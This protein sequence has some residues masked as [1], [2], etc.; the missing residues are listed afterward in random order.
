MEVKD[1]AVDD[2]IGGDPVTGAP[3][4][5]T[6]LD[7]IW[8]LQVTHRSEL[9]RLRYTLDAQ[10]PSHLQPEIIGQY[11]EINSIWH[12]FLRGLVKAALESSGSVKRS[13]AG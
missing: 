7:Y 3:Q 9:A 1:R 10:F 8:D 13:R 2:T 11:R 12:Q 4:K 5:K 6:K